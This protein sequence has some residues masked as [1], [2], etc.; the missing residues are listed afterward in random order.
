MVPLSSLTHLSLLAWI[1]QQIQ[2]QGRVRRG[3]ELVLAARPLLRLARSPSIQEPTSGQGSAVESEQIRHENHH[4]LP[5]RFPEE[6]LI[7]IFLWFALSSPVIVNGRHRWLGALRLRSRLR[8]E[9]GGYEREEPEMGTHP[10]PAN[11][12]LAV[13]RLRRP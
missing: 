7:L 5:T 10:G 6:A 13:H 4:N 12:I 1:A 2:A 11:F 8:A 9:A 3:R